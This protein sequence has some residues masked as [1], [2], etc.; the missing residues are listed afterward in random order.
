[1]NIPR[2]QIEWRPVRY[3]RQ[4][5]SFNYDYQMTLNRPLSDW[6]VWDYWEV[7]RVE[8]MRKHLKPGNV[9]FD[10]GTEQGWCNLVYAQM[11]G[12]ENIVLMEPT[13][14]FWPNIQALWEKN[15]GEILPKGYYQGLLSDKTTDERPISTTWPECSAGDLIDRNSYKLIHEHGNVIPQITIADYVRKSGIVPDA[16]T[17]DVEGAELLVLMGAEEIL[18]SHDLK[19]WVSEHDDLALANYNVKPDDVK[20]YMASLGYVME[21][22]GTDHERHVYYHK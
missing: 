8:S 18:K 16:L 4:G 6:D 22:L 17:I 13:P 14:E 7:V 1:M 15:F 11:V 3:L 19:V 10:V 5:Q 21:D 9:L 20:N 2:D 12:P